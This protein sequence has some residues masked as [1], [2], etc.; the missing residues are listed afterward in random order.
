MLMESEDMER[1]DFE[2]GEKGRPWKRREVRWEE[3]SLMRWSKLIIENWISSASI[4]A[5]V[6]WDG[7]DGGEGEDEGVEDEDE[8]VEEGGGFEECEVAANRMTKWSFRTPTTVWETELRLNLWC[9]FISFSPHPPW[10]EGERKTEDSVIEGIVRDVNDEAEAKDEDWDEKGN[11]IF[12]HIEGDAEDGDEKGGGDERNEEE[13]EG[14]D[15]R[16]ERD[17]EDEED[18]ES[19]EMFFASDLIIWDESEGREEGEDDDDDD[20]GGEERKVKGRGE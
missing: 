15:E 3:S 18:D 6:S 1:E 9:S 20:E 2:E 19:W 12:D 13:E 5:S 8:G 11:E 7:R 14:D 17:G 4:V 10:S 16:K